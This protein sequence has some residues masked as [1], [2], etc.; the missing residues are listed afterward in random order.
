VDVGAVHSEFASRLPGD[1]ELDRAH[2]FSV[3]NQRFAESLEME[4]NYAAGWREW[5]ISLYRQER[6]N[7]A[8]LKAKRA[9]ELKAE[10]FPA[11]FLKNLE[12][13]VSQS[14]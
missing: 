11:G 1:K 10:A 2:H 3:A 7:E 4:P 5:A 8:W 12:N 6:Y 9:M 13:K 14:K